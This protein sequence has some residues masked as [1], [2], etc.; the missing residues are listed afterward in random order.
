MIDLL[1]MIIGEMFVE[2]SQLDAI[3]ST[4]KHDEFCNILPCTDDSKEVS[5]QKLAYIINKIS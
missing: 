2:D 3:R 1:S 4:H 5:Q